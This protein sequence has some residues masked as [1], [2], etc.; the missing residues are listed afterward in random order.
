MDSR[1]S[2]FLG[3]VQEAPIEKMGAYILSDEL[4][5]LGG[6]LI[7]TVLV[8]KSAFVTS[9]VGDKLPSSL[10]GAGMSC[11]LLILSEG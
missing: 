7:S 6:S 8:L 2:G 5:D 11:K 1:L 3:N 4:P 9:P 10:L